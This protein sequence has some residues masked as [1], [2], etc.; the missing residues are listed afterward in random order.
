MTKYKR[1]LIRNLQKLKDLMAKDP[2]F[3]KIAIIY[4]VY[5]IV[6]VGYA[7]HLETGS[8]SG[9]YLPP[10][11]LLS[12]ASP[13][14]LVNILY[15]PFGD[16]HNLL[17][18]QMIIASVVWL[19]FALA[20]RKMFV[21][22]LGLVLIMFILGYSLVGPVIS[23]QWWAL[24]EGLT[25]SL[26]VL[27]ITTFIWLYNAAERVEKTRIVLLQIIVGLLLVLT[28]PQMFLLI[29][30][31]EL[32]FAFRYRPKKE[33]KVLIVMMFSFLVATSVWSGMRLEHVANNSKFQLWYAQNN[34]LSK[35]GYL[36]FAKDNGVNC[37][38]I[39]DVTGSIVDFS[40]ARPSFPALCPEDTSW[41][42]SK[43]ASWP[44]WFL[45][46]PVSVIS[47]F[48]AFLLNAEAVNISPQRNPLPSTWNDLFLSTSFPAVSS[49]FFLMFL[50]TLYYL[51]LGIK[52]RIRIRPLL[53]SLF[54]LSNAIFYLFVM[55][56]SDG[57]EL[58][59]H[60]VPVLTMFPIAGFLWPHLYVRNITTNEK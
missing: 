34:L 3:S 10:A 45:D 33:K 59:R 38:T 9:R 27:W 44:Q 13:G 37:K 31:I 32:L 16:H 7:R 60:L 35:P 28:R 19:T 22:Q 43:S 12:D 47:E 29:G 6:F 8:D 46:R 17:L 39:L 40:T 57:I 42:S 56:A 48:R 4:L 20:I 1:I 49:M 55:W 11:P 50:S 15:S 36:D 54:I 58:E 30:P 14:V 41:L 52:L 5:S 51:L 53:L 2:I 21:D 23:W 25:V 26:F 18:F 24:T